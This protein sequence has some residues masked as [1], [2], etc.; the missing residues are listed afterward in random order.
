[1]ET[2]SSSVADKGAGFDSEVVE[3]QGGLGLVGLRERVRL[4]GGTISI[5]SRPGKGSTIEVR[6]P[7]DKVVP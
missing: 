1:M 2:S 3:S 4:A 6:I 5:R 7:L